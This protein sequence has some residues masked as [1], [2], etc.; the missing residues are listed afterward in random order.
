MIILTTRLGFISW[1]MAIWIFCCKYFLRT[2]TNPRNS[3][4]LSSVMFKGKNSILKILLQKI[5]IKIISREPKPGCVFLSNEKSQRLALQICL[6]K[7]QSW[8]LVGNGI[9][10]FN[11]KVLISLTSKYHKLSKN[12]FFKNDEI[13]RILQFWGQR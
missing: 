13:C 11:L 3:F 10:K 7:D 4:Q 8:V 12:C 9:L 2:S 5:C 1:G 6:T